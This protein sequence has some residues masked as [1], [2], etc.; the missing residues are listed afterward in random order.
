MQRNGAVG[1]W[2]WNSDGFAL[3]EFA[4][5]KATIFGPFLAAAAFRMVPMAISPARVCFGIVV[6]DLAQRSLAERAR[7]PS[8]K[9]PKVV[10]TKA[11]VHMSWTSVP[12][13]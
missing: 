2:A 12:Y 5:Q 11:Y 6:I 1:R 9:K 10:T 7:R 3:S 13:R 8:M 4:P